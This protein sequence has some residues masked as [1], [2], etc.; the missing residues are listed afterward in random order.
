[1]AGAEWIRISAGCTLCLTHL[2]LFFLKDAQLKINKY[3]EANPPSPEKLKELQEKQ[4]REAAQ[5][6]EK[7]FLDEMVKAMRATIPEGQGM[8]KPSFAENLYKENLDQEYVKN[9]VESGGVGLSDLIYEQLKSQIEQMQGGA[10][11]PGPSGPMPVD[12]GKGSR[13]KGIAAYEQQ[14]SQV[15]PLDD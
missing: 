11:K 1:M 6:Y 8:I 3:F 15:K 9:W 4:M 12:G 14:A 10:V 7:Y 13:A 2:P 5:A